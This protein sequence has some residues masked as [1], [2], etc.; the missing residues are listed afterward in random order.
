MQQPY[1]CHRNNAKSITTRFHH[2]WGVWCLGH[3]QEACMYMILSISSQICGSPAV[4]G[5]SQ[6]AIK[7]TIDVSR[8]AKVGSLTH[9]TRDLDGLLCAREPVTTVS[10]VSECSGIVPLQF[11]F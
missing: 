1:N 5:R 10:R 2:L 8:L 6:P 7:I 3:Q 11:C 9:L 4:P